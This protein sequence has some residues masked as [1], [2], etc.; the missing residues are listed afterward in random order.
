MKFKLINRNGEFPR[1]G[2]EFIDSRTGM[3]FDG[4]GFDRTV[5]LI[6]AH[7]RLNPNLYPTIDAQYLDTESV[8]RELEYYTCSRLNN[9]GRYCEPADK[10]P[11]VRDQ[12]PQ[13]DLPR[14]CPECGST[15][16]FANLCASCGG[17]RISSYSCICGYLIGK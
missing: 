17:R 11:I 10:S 2:Y 8:A 9:N 4:I 7:R 3:T 16:G 13:V 6:V 5:S 14:T 12:G 15:R 1:G